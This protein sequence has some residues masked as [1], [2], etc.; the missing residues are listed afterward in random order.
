MS[1][2][3]AI[4]LMTMVSGALEYAKNTGAG[5]AMVQAAARKQQGSQIAAGQLRINA[6]QQEAASQQGAQDI[7]RQGELGQSRILAL[8][9]S[10]G[11]DTR[12]PT[13]MGL[14][15][16]LMSEQ[17]YRMQTAIYQGNEAARGMRMQAD[18]QEIMGEAAVSDAA[19]A[20]KGADFAATAGL[21]KTAASMYDKYNRMAGA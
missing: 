13:I 4:P 6:G 5:N 21:F 7:A 12:D 2:P 9:A 19:A 18:A 8:A 11:A 15:A 3:Y 10:Q 1:N 16:R 20:K 14:R 17:A